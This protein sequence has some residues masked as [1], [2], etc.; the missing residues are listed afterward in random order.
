M[1]TIK[2]KR[3]L[4]VAR[5]QLHLSD[6]EYRTILRNHGGVESSRDLNT[7]KLDAVLRAMKSMGFVQTHSNRQ[8]GERHGF[9]SPAQVGLIRNLWAIYTD[10]EGTDRTLGRFLDKKFGISDIA[11]LDYPTAP[12]VITALRAMASRKA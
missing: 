9:A 8:F 5:K 4:G 12:R 1:L 11:F 7:D 3:L 6:D 2:Q 10:G